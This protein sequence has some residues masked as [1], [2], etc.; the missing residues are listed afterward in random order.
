MKQLHDVYPQFL[1]GIKM[2][3]IQQRQHFEG[4]KIH[5][6][7]KHHRKSFKLGTVSGLESNQ[8]PVTDGVLR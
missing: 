1:A 6:Y 3:D 7:T 5:G 2:W 8:T 4:L